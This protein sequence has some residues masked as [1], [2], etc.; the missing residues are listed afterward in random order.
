MHISK[1]IIL[2]TLIIIIG[3]AIAAGIGLFLEDGGRSYLFSTLR[4]Q[5]VKIYGQGLYQ[6]DTLFFA[7]GYKG[8]D[9]VVLFLGIPLLLISVI[10][11]WRGSIRG[12]L[13]L[14]GILGYFLYV[15]SSMA[16]GAAYNRLFLLYIIIFSSSLFAFIRI[17]SSFRVEPI[18]ACIK[19][20]LPRQ[21]L[22]VFM[23]AAG[24]VTLFVWGS[25]LLEALLRNAPP[26]RLDSYTTMVTFALDL[27]IITPAT[28]LCGI[29]VIRS[30]PWGY[31]MAAPLLTLVILL[32]PQIILSTIFQKSAG[33]AL[34][35][36][37]M[38]GP[39]AGFV[40]LGLIAFWLFIAILR[41]LPIPP[42]R[43][44]S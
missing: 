15:Y 6:Y 17:F 2:L 32:A 12:Q 37:E 11:Y 26:D 1:S 31:V 44:N 24:F 16:L 25:P 35:T 34:T 8:Q 7:A 19:G 40:L 33:V 4:G 39:V 5:T 13:L 29:Y 3:A 38:S 42:D 43:S 27:A 9:T 21:S 23:I 20:G 30:N 36:G 10:L 41:A 14:T 22:S 18:S 28:F